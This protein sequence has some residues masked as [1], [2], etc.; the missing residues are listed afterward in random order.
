MMN[1]LGRGGGNVRQPYLPA[2]DDALASIRE[3]LAATGLTA[4]QGNQAAAE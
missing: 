2:P 3:E 1:V 4:A